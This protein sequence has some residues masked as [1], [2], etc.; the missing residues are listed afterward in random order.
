MQR[1]AT[2]SL[3]TRAAVG[4]VGAN[5]NKLFL[6]RESGW[7]RLWHF[8]SGARPHFVFF[9]FKDTTVF[10]N[11]RSETGKH[12]STIRGTARASGCVDV[13]VSVRATVCLIMQVSDPG[14]CNSAGVNRASATARE[15]TG[16]VQQRG[17]QP[18]E[19]N[20]A[21]QRVCGRRCEC[22]SYGVPLYRYGRLVEIRYSFRSGGRAA[23]RAATP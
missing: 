2:L 13:V 4:G 1:T 14:Q 18:D 16:R 22:A 12:G 15:S 23:S 8:H 20:S 9:V 10:L 11:R 7:M 17:S 5:E 6:G 3:A 21:G 19:C